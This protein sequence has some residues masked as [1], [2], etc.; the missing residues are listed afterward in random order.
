MGNAIG[1]KKKSAK[2]MKID[3]TTFKVKPL[4]LAM[5][6]LR[7]HPGHDLLESDDVK[8]HGVRARPLHPTAPLKPGKLY[9]L[10]E[11]PRRLQ[12][13]AWSGNL[14]VSAKERLESL[15]IIRRSMSDMSLANE[16]SAYATAGDVEE[17]KG[18]GVRMR[19][20]LPKVLVEKLM[21]ESKDATEAAEK[22]M[23]LCAEKDC[24]ATRAVHQTLSSVKSAQ[25]QEKHARFALAPD[26]I[27]G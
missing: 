14:Q 17:T 27:I 23:K 25:L 20:R 24:G 22:I 21:Q 6:L 3:G 9:F 16:A 5:K 12:R 19:V 8:C 11:L 18:G 13:R 4:V 1:A 7:D 15:K 2:V 26:E 10:V